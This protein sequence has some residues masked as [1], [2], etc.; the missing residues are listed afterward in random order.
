[1]R[2]LKRPYS[3]SLELVGREAAEGLEGSQLDA[4]RKSECEAGMALKTVAVG[5]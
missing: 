2:T 4:A 3:R 5:C 1:M